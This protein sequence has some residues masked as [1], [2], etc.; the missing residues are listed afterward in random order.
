P[1]ARNAHQSL[2]KTLNV[3]LSD[4]QEYEEILLIDSN[5]VVFASTFEG[6]EGMT[7]KGIDYFQNGL[8]RTYIQHVFISSITEK[9]T[10]VISTPI[11]SETGEVLGVFAVRLNLDIFFDFVEDLTGLGQ[12][13]ETIVA[14]E[15]A[16]EIIFM[17]PTRHDYNAAL[18]RKI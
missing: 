2:K 4:Q 18:V 17:A 3:I 13:G 11:K 1:K 6:H 15:I 12:T 16:K 5:G 14:K 7:A 8:K 9:L 10:M